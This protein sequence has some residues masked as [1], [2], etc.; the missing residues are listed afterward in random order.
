[1]IGV[2]DFIGYYDWTF[3]YFRRMHGENAVQKY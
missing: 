3:E 2:Q 1:M